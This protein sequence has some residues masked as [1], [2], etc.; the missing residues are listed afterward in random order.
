M[1]NYYNVRENLKSGEIITCLELVTDDNEYSLDE[2]IILENEEIEKANEICDSENKDLKKRG[3]KNEKYI[4]IN[5]EVM[6]DKSL[7]C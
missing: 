7:Q 2:I 6:S 4:V 3:V 1:K 5:Y